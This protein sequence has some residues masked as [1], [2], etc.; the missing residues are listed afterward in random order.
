MRAGAGTLGGMTGAGYA[1]WRAG[2]SSL[3][4]C[5]GARQTRLSCCLALPCLPASQALKANPEG[6]PKEFKINA[7]YI[8]KFGQ[9]SLG[10]TMEGC[11]VV[12]VVV[13]GWGDR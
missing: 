6:A 12:V 7:N 13:V 3:L 8:S 1:A 5:S 11:V 10:C 9:V 2:G 4:L